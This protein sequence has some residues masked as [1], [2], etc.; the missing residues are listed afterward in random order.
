MAERRPLCGDL[1][2]MPDLNRPSLENAF[3]TVK[4]RMV[5]LL[6]YA[7]VVLSAI[8]DEP[9]LLPEHTDSVIV[10]AVSRLDWFFQDVLSLGTRHRELILRRHFARHG[11]KDAMAWDLPRLVKTVR[12]RVSFEDGGRRLDNIFR[13]VFNCSVWPND[14]V[15]DAVLDLVLLR[16]FIVHSSG[17]DWSLDGSMPA[18]YASQFRHADVLSVRRYGSFAVYSV[19]SYRALQFFRG[20][21][22]GVVEQLQYL[23]ERL[24]HDM[25]W[26]EHSE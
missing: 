7:T 26:A 23:E 6:E 2:G 12:R 16:N 9:R 4:K 18:D 20:A 10:L 24:V 21:V 8:T 14:K 13:L 19:D 25:S 15:Q 11:H 22:Q 5:S 1:N 3:D 17:Q